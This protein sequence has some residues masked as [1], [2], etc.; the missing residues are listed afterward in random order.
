MVEKEPGREE[1]TWTALARRLVLGEVDVM[2]ELFRRLYP[3]LVSYLT[4]R[5]GGGLLRR[6]DVEEVASEALL[7]LWLL[8][9]T[10]DPARG[11]ARLG[12]G[13]CP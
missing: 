8:R 9:E 7:R 13:H 10:Y 4:G 12:V 11:P 2:E 5:F 6:E 1:E 3:R